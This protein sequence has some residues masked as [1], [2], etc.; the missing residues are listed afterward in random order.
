MTKEEIEREIEEMRQM[1][2]P[3]LLNKLKG[4]GKN[5]EEGKVVRF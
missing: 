5:R 3:K 1:L 2:N 4:L